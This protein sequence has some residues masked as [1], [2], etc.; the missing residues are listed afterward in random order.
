MPDT[1]ATA[2]SGS[3]VGSLD[4]ITYHLYLVRQFNLNVIS[5]AFGQ[6]LYPI[7]IDQAAPPLFCFPRLQEPGHRPAERRRTD[8]G[9][10][11]SQ[12]PAAPL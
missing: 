9:P 1:S 6:T 3:P 4:L 7:R 8:D 12:S 11:C 2:G 10:T 5:A